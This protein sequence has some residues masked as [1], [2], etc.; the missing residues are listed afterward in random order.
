[1][2]C[3]GARDCTDAATT[4]WL[5]T[6]PSSPSCKE[7]LWRCRRSEPVIQQ[8]GGSYKREFHLLSSGARVFGPVV[9]MSESLRRDRMRPLEYPGAPVCSGHRRQL[10]GVQRG[11]HAV[12]QQADPAPARAF[13]SRRRLSSPSRGGPIPPGRG[14]SPT[15][16]PALSGPALLLP[17]RRDPRAWSCHPRCRE[18]MGTEVTRPPQRCSSEYLISLQFAACHI[19]NSWGNNV[20]QQRE[21]IVLCRVFFLPKTTAKICLNNVMWEM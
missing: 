9:E 1:M 15:L 14:F 17:A 21:A 2:F 13:D 12:W 7:K 11:N 4:S 6:T 3:Q 16:R 20:G 8:T 10:S 5:E 19:C 18:K